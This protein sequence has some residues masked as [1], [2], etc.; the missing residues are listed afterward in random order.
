MRFLF[1]LLDFIIFF[2][3]AAFIITVR[4]STGSWDLSFFLSNCKV[5]VPVFIVNMILLVIFSFYDLRRSY[6]RHSN[7]F[8]GLLTAFIVS[9]VVSVGCKNG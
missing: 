7:H 3:T 1:F 2:V 9:F 4:S 8:A 5:L 6:E